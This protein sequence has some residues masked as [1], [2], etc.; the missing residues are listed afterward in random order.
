[1]LETIKKHKNY[2]F[3]LFIVILIL[4]GYHYTYSVRMESKL[5]EFRTEIQLKEETIEEQENTI[6]EYKNR[7][8]DRSEELR[9][10]SKE[11]NDMS[12]ELSFWRR[13]AVIVK[14]T[15]E[16]YH[17]YGCQYVEGREFWIYNIEAAEGMGYEPC[18]VCDPGQ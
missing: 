6:S 14:R 9:D 11:L 18:S 10:I 3:V 8:A 17:T 4:Y 5:E 13:Y 15:G 7:A 12:R 16:K 1:M 2:I